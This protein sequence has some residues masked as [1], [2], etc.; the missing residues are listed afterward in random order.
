MLKASIAKRTLD[1]ITVV[2]VAFAHFKKLAFPSSMP[3]HK[4]DSKNVDSRGGS[5]MEAN[6]N[7][8][9]YKT[10]ASNDKDLE[11]EEKKGGL[12][13]RKSEEPPDR[14]SYKVNRIDNQKREK[15]SSPHFTSKHNVKVIPKHKISVQTQPIEK[16]V[17]I[18]MKV[19]NLFLSNVSPAP[20]SNIETGHNNKGENYQEEG[21][22]SNKKPDSQKRSP[23]EDV[24]R[25]IF[26]KKKKSGLKKD[27]G[28]NF[29]EQMHQKISS[30]KLIKGGKKF[31]TTIGS[32][33]TI[34]SS[35]KPNPSMKQPKR[36]GISNSPVN[37]FSKRPDSKRSERLNYKPIYK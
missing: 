18:I 5:A 17:Q 12:N 32:K 11:Q 16:P 13:G 23:K 14:I 7:A 9:H 33:F 8:S 26:A 27:K 2:M 30:K 22:Y 37:Q 10:M 4:I 15:N 24:S 21:E 25:N 36:I 6:D 29:I 35:K 28:N 31:A 34:N 19:G 1:N 20:A 3:D